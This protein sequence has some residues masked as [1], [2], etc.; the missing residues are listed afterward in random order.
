MQDN[1]E[2]F[3]I[4]VTGLHPSVT[5]KQLSDF[6]S[7]CGKI[8]SLTLRTKDDSVEGVL[9]F[10]KEASAKTALLLNNALI[11]DKP[12]TVQPYTEARQEVHREEDAQS[13][14]NLDKGDEPLVDVREVPDENITQRPVT[15]QR[16]SFTKYCKILRNGY[17]Y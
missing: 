9:F 17:E 4:L 8:S 11:K 14:E 3:P 1:Q 6:F 7:F 16:V 13:Q 2:Q 10:E 5:S 15:G 12:I